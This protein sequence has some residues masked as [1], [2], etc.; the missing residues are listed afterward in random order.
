MILPLLKCSCATFVLFSLAPALNAADSRNAST[1]STPPVTREPNPNNLGSDAN[2][3]PLRRAPRTGHV[4][5]YDEAKV[6]TYTLPDPLVSNDRRPIRDAETWFNL[7]RPEIL[8][9][10]EME[11]YGRNPDRMPTVRFETVST[12]TISVSGKSAT[13]RHGILHIG[14]GSGAQ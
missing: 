14:S 1:R 13:H 9:A 6:G 4:S 11:I 8:K 5:N 7:R 2:G 10:Y 12:E 3:N